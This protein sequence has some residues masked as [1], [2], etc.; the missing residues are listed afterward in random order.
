[1]SK[2]KKDGGYPE[3]RLEGLGSDAVSISLWG[4]LSTYEVRV[5]I[6]TLQAH[7]G[8]MDA[9]DRAKV[10]RECFE[11]PPP[12]ALDKVD[13]P[14][15][16]ALWLRTC[17]YGLRETPR[18]RELNKNFSSAAWKAARADCGNVEDAAAAL[19]DWLKRCE[20]NARERE[21][22]TDE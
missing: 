17:M 13:S 6:E 15:E 19:D 3:Q 8:R 7:L 22:K 21:K 10:L 14:S 9:Q 16:L 18:K 4:Q 2:K 12:T 1:M 5:V 11:T 20:T